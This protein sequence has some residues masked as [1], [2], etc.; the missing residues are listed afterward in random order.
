M[1]IKHLVTSGCSFSDNGFGNRWPH[2]LAQE[3]NLR[4]Y[5]F[6]HGSAGNDYI[7]Q[8]IIFKIN[9]L[10]KQGIDPSEIAVFVMWSGIDRQGIFISKQETLKYDLLLN[11]GQ[12][13][14]I[15]F[16]FMKETDVGSFVP[17]NPTVFGYPDTGWLLGSPNCKWLNQNITDLKRLHF[18]NFYTYEDCLIKSL[19]SML[20]LQWLCDSKGIYLR[21]MTFMN[22]FKNTTYENTKHLLELLDF[23]KWIFW[24]ENGGLFEY[25]KDNN[26]PFYPDAVHPLPESH[27]HFIKNHVCP[28]LW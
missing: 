26:L 6:G 3:Y 24:K 14:P 25:T 18:E 5:N 17:Q 12:N 27:L 20:Q 16:L 10:L 22:I 11:E 23:S 7:S 13:N 9:N 2:W 19:L 8:S 28:K 21:N 1:K 4:L 15:N